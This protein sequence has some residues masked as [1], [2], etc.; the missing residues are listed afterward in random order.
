MGFSTG[1]DFW[2]THPLENH[3]VPS[4]RTS[5]G[6]NGVRGTKFFNGQPATCIP[7][8]TG[9]AS[10]WDVDLIRTAGV[11]MGKECKAKGV[12]CWLGPTVNIQ[13]SPLGG[14]G[15]ESFSEDPYLSGWVFDCTDLNPGI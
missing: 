14:R 1:K 13:R 8:G 10:S 9:L 5:D 2:H 3:N 12:H 11:L 7:C 4:I 15:F 6:P